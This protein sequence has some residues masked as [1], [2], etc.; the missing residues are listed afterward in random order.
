MSVRE[1]EKVDAAQF[2][3]VRGLVTAAGLCWDAAA[4]RTETAPQRSPDLPI[5]HSEAAQ[6]SPGIEA[7]VL[8]FPLPPQTELGL[9]KGTMGY[10]CWT[11]W[12][13]CCGR[14]AESPRA[15]HPLGG[16]GHWKWPSSPYF[17]RNGM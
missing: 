17:H 1:A 12:G 14:R 8:H 10:H 5:E 2:D 3:S 13:K 15:T 16:R 11:K 9:V 7:Q 6:T 4:A